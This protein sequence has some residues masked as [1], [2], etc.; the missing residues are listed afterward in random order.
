MTIIICIDDTDNME[1]G[2]G[3]G[4]LAEELSL[5]IEAKKLGKC[6]RVTRHQLL[7]HE[8]I[9][10]TSHNSSMCFSAEINDEDS[11]QDIIK[12]AGEFLDK[13]H[14]KESDPGLCIASVGKLK[15]KDELIQFGRLAKVKVLTKE[16]AYETAEIIGVH[17]SEHGGTGLGVIGALAG[18]GLRLSGNDG[19]YKGNISIAAEGDVM[20]VLTICKT[21]EIDGV[22]SIDGSVLNDNEKI[23]FGRIKKAVHINGKAILLVA[24]NEDE[25]TAGWITCNKKQLRAFDNERMV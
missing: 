19:E 16:E 17:L 14:A 3:T 4:T 20:D 9:P 1:K 22:M 21:G 13:E 15:N 5:L 18:A 23:K 8:D 11:L 6:Q 10:Y 7:L 25:E 2:R 24:P 12:L